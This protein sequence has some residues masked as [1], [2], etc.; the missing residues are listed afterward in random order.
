MDT[1]IKR[2]Y[3][4]SMK[5]DLLKE[6]I[7]TPI[8]KK[9]ETVKNLLL[10][11]Y[12]F[13]INTLDGEVTNAAISNTSR[14]DVYYTSMLKPFSNLTHFQPILSLAISGQCFHQ[15]PLRLKMFKSSQR[16]LLQ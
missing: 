11:S 13:T 15:V 1:E 2:K 16:I 14:N 7:C 3:P 10:T 9:I 12:A 6:I 4:V 5:H 8:T